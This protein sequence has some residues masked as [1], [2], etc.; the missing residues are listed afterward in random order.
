MHT[1]ISS[2][3]LKRSWH[4][5]PRWA[6]AGNKNT[7]STHHPQRWNVTTSVVRLKN[8][9]IHT[10]THTKY[11]TR[12]GEP[13]RYSWECRWRTENVLVFL[14]TIVFLFF[15]AFLCLINFLT[16]E[17]KPQWVISSVT[18]TGGLRVWEGS[19]D[20]CQY[21]VDSDTPV[22]NTK[23]LE[24]GCGAGLPGL[25]A[26]KLGAASVHFQD[27]VRIFVSFLFVFL[28]WCVC[29]CVCESVSL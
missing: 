13:Q 14:L 8:S 24:L 15:C 9:H 22:A 7:R 3:G 21:L 17:V 12:N 23:V 2:H 28:F 5:W 25:L 19:C 16:C 11:L 1:S 18:V 26:A 29:V 20:L 6:S 10:H 27:F 4:S